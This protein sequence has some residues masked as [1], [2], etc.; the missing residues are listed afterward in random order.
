MGEVLLLIQNQQKCTELHLYWVLGRRNDFGPH[1]RHA[2]V[3]AGL[4]SGPNRHSPPILPD[5]STQIVIISPMCQMD[6]FM[7]T[8]GPSSQFTTILTVVQLEP[9]KFFHKILNSLL[10][11]I[12]GITKSIHVQPKKEKQERTIK[13]KIIFN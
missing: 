5:E 6:L 12:H 7:Y 11:F 4:P 9:L 8:N 3:W 13:A 10:S 1:T 2:R